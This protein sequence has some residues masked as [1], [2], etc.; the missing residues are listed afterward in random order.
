VHGIEVFP[1]V[2]AQLLG[3]ARRDKSKPGGVQYQSDVAQDT[4]DRV[5]K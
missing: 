3:A 5:E 2:S 1:Q 4:H